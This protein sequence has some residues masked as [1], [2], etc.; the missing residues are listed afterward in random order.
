MK[1]KIP[2]MKEHPNAII[3]KVYPK[4]LEDYVLS[5]GLTIN[6]AQVYI[7]LCESCARGKKPT[8]TELMP[9][10]QRIYCGEMAVRSIRATLGSLCK[11]RKTP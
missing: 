5:D 8:A 4:S 6:E 7:D 10:E 9:P 3:T 11:K 1:S 2:P